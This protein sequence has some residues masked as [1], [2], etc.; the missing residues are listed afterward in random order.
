M[1]VIVFKLICYPTPIIRYASQGIPA[2]F[3]AYDPVT[4]DP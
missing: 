1:D 3:T 2:I 4:D